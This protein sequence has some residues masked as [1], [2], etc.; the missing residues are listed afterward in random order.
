[1]IAVALL[2]SFVIDTVDD[3]K[4][5]WYKFERESLMTCVVEVS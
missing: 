1:M 2:V 5:D 3:E 4:K